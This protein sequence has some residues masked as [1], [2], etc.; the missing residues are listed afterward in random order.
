MNFTKEKQI[1]LTGFKAIAGLDEVGRGAWAGP[2]VAAA[3]LLKH[4]QL[5]NNKLDFIRLVKDSKLLSLNKRRELFN[6][7]TKNF[8]WSIGLVEAQGIDRVGIVEANKLAMRRAV[9]NLKIKPDY[10]LVDYIKDIGLKVSTQGVKGG[11]NKVFLIAAASIVAKVWR[12]SLMVDYH[13]RFNR[14]YFNQHKGYGTKLHAECIKKYGVS[15][16]H[17]RSFT[18]IR[19]LQNI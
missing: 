15:R 18:P 14:W 6:L 11:D 12:D 13:R 4:R 9:Q 7:I 17:R 19:V 1:F 8:I 3:V 2:I 10:L 5:I 16:L